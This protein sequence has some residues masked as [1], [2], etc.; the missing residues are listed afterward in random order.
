MTQLKLKLES[1]YQKSVND[2]KTDVERLK[3]KL[4]KALTEKEIEIRKLTLSNENGP[5]LSS[6]QLESQA[7]RERAQTLKTENE[8]LRVENDGLTKQV[9]RQETSLKILRE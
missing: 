1:D 6:L 3:D 2:S 9:Q 4:T 7:H 5:R 8:R